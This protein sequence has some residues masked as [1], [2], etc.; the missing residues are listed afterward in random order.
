MSFNSINFMIFFPIVVVVLFCIPKRIRLVWLLVVSYYFYMC[1][2][3]GYALFLAFSTVSTYITGI[4]LERAGGS[5]QKRLT[6]GLCCICNL[7]VLFLFKYSNFAIESLNYLLGLCGI[8]TV[9]YR[10]DLLLPVGISYYTF[11]A[12]GYIIDVYRGQAA[13]HNVVKYGLFVSFFPQL[14]AGPIERASNMLGQFEEL[15]KRKLWDDE[16]VK[17][18][19]LLILWGLFQKIILADRLALYVDTVYGNYQEYGLTVLTAATV[20]LAFQIYCDFDGY[21]NMA[22]GVAEVMGIKIM[23]N[24]E[25]PYLATNIK[26]FWRRWH[27]SLTSWFRDYLYIPLGG[28]RKGELRKNLNIFIVFCISGL[29]HGASWNFVIW[30]AIHGIIQIIHN[31]YSSIRKKEKESFS[32]KLRNGIVTFAVVDFAWLF[33]YTG[34][35]KEAFGIIGQMTSVLGDFSAIREVLGTGDRNLLFMGLIILFSV[36]IVHERG[37]SI[38]QWVQ[39]QEM[40][41]RYILYIGIICACLYLGVQTGTDAARGF[42]Y[43]RF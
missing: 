15:Q 39:K 21:T 12:V 34:S 7:G 35:L 37:I 14:G 31:L 4:L 23:K 22:C 3:P 6:I 42:I 30:G 9:D 25:R 36:D 27:I 38:R 33:F 13:E 17:N 18:G 32:S 24:F 26:E 40:W 19:L 29:W 41:F 16:R 2:N 5:K 28:N 8:K 10:F 43:F 11:Q 20:L 1:W